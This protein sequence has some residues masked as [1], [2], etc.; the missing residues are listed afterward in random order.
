[1]AKSEYLC[2]KKSVHVVYMRIETS[3]LVQRWLKP[4]FSKSG[5]SDEEKKD[6]ELETLFNVPLNIPQ[7]KNLCITLFCQNRDHT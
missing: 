5:K 4:V 7:M 3:S 1:M 6:K 2:H